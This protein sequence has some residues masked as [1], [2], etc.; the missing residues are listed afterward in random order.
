MP[1]YAEQLVGGHPNSLGSTVAVVEDVLARPEK[2][3][4]LYACY[5]SPDEVVR[6]RTSNAFKRIAKTKPELVAP[7]LDK[8]IG[9]VSRINQASA[10]WTLAQ[11]FLI[12]DNY[13]TSEQK[14]RITPHFQKNLH[15]SDWIVLNA[16]M[17]VLTHHAKGNSE[18]RDWLLSALP[19]LTRDERKSVRRRAEKYLETI[20]KY[21]DAK[22]G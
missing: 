10:Q 14:A 6:L 18:L 15:H 12:L 1:T 16:T 5:A 9:E 4:E 22:S 20:K 17:E 21:P 2:I 13:V 7:F 19:K 3:T 11:L 8:F